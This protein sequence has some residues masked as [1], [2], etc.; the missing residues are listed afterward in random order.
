MLKNRV[1]AFSDGVLAI[2]ITIMVLELK[3]PKGG[4]WNS[5][6]P[7]FDIFLG[8]V[9][10]FIYLSIYWI[11]HHHIFQVVKKVNGVI[12]WANIHLLFWLSLFPF[13]T[14]WAGE[15]HFSSIPT[16]LYGII[17]LMAAVA[18]HLLITVL[19]KEPVH[20]EFFT[21]MLKNDI[22]GKSSILFYLIAVLASLYAPKV[23]VSIYVLVAMMWLIPDKR[24]EKYFG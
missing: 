8:H 23:S 20:K 10:S 3:V 17:L 24:I 14:T 9:M 16:L 2:I 19:K 4:D 11:N 22:K 1:E 13:V 6:E 21:Q 12:L 5:L 7:L 18:Y 15:N